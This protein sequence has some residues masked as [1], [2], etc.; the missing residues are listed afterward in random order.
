M[1]R[2]CKHGQLARSCNLC[3]AA[4]AIKAAFLEGYSCGYSEGI[5]DGHP[6]S[7]RKSDK[8]K[9][10]DKESAWL[11]SDAWLESENT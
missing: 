5:S 1:K 7:G 11:C 8:S 10:E 2:D 4:E 3:E 9:A 6:L